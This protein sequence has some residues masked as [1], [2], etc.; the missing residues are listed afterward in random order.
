VTVRGISYIS[1]LL[2]QSVLLYSLVRYSRHQQKE[3]TLWMLQKEYESQLN[4]YLNLNEDD[5]IRQL[6]HDLLNYWKE[7]G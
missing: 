7:R 3:K 1:I 6:R 4:A 5:Q 2:V